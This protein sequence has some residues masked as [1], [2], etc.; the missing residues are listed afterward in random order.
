MNVIISVNLTIKNP[1]KLYSSFVSADNSICVK[2]IMQNSFLESL[3][4][5]PNATFTIFYLIFESLETLF[6]DTTRFS[7]ITLIIRSSAIL[8]SLD[9]V[10]VSRQASATAKFVGI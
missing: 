1:M 7:K 9:L 5:I 10:L 3:T 6:G 8:I 2:S 4:N